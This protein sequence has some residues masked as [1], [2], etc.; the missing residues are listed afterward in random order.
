MSGSR[1]SSYSTSNSARIFGSS[2]I[3]SVPVV[4]GYH[5]GNPHAREIVA[6]YVRPEYV[7]SQA[8]CSWPFG[9]HART[10]ARTLNAVWVSCLPGTACFEGGERSHRCLQCPTKRNPPLSLKCTFAHLYSIW[11]IKLSFDLPVM[12]HSR[13]PDSVSAPPLPPTPTRTVRVV[14]YEN[15]LKG[16]PLE[17][18][19]GGF[20]EG[21][22]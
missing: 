11:A 3:S 22:G 20:L 9:T 6:A 12:D 2:C 14:L 16:G 5:H 8:R 1:F 21:G 13:S 7:F 18:L 19:V 17:A 4:Q 15:D 10:H